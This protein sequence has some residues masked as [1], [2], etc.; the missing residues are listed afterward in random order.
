[1]RIQEQGERVVID[2]CVLAV[3]AVAD[4]LLRIAERSS[5]FT[6]RW[7]GRILEEMHR[8]HLKFGWGKC[9]S[10]SF[11]ACLDPA[12]PEAS[13][14]GYEPLIEQCT[15]EEG[16]RHVLAAAI[17][18]QVARIV[19]FNLDDFSKAALAP[20]GITAVHPSDYLLELYAKDSRAVRKALGAQ[21]R[22]RRMKVEE[23]LAIMAEHVPDFA[24]KLLEEMEVR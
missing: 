17:K 7:T 9:A 19:T 3:F 18:S 15:N 24:S 16:D 23:R 12:F 8:A 14:E 11:H 22:K 4:L 20:W 6:P 13:I 2:A 5:L 10:A 1:M 21:A